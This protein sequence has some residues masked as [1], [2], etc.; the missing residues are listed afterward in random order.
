MKSDKNYLFQGEEFAENFK[1]IDSLHI[2]RR[3]DKENRSYSLE[4]VCDRLVMIAFE[5]SPCLNSAEDKAFALLTCASAYCQQFIA[6]IDKL[7]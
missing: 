6:E 2:F 3:I 7:K 5:D 4:N 1:R